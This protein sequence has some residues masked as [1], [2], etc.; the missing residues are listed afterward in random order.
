[1]RIYHEPVTVQFRD[2]PAQFIWRGRLLRVLSVQT[3]TREA[4]SWWRHP[5]RA[6]E[7]LEREVWRVEA[8]SGRAWRGVYELARTAGED[9]WQLQG[10]ED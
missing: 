9:D 7:P 6:G 8:E 10:V 2:A 5:E 4:T 1:M 3:L